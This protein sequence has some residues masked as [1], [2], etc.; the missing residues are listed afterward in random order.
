MPAGFI[1]PPELPPDI[2]ELFLLTKYHPDY[3]S[4]VYRNGARVR[5]T[6]GYGIFSADGAC[7]RT[8]HVMATFDDWRQALGELLDMEDRKSVV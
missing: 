5:G 8:M 1:V 7:H 4:P 3:K 6:G 2:A